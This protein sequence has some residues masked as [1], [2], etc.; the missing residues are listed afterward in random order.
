MAIAVRIARA[1]TGREKVAVCGY[2]GW[3]DWYLA[4]NL[5]TEDALGEH[6]LPGL[7]PTGVPRALVGTTLPF[8]YNHSEELAA[9]IAEHGPDLAA[10][11]M[12]PIRSEQPRTGFLDEVT[13]LARACG[14]VLIVDEVSAGF[15]MNSGGAHLVLGLSPDVAVFSKA[16]G[17]GY[18]IAAV[19]GRGPV[20]QAAQD[21][22]I[23]S[24][25][26]TERIGPVAALATVRKHRELD[27]GRHLMIIGRKVQSGWR[28][29]ARQHGLPIVIS[30]IPPLS[31]FSF[32][33]PNAMALKALYV[34]LMLDHGFLASTSFYAMLAHTEDHVDRYLEAVDEVFG[35]LA[36][37]DESPRSASAV[38]GMPATGRPVASRVW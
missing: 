26:W 16:L 33:A 29:L 32:D 25:Y 28:R 4:A 11:V 15:R 7:Q 20:M 34:Q 21:S 37:L 9:I 6:L 30:G 8:R 13:R 14:S 10:V 3:H 23:S 27:V 31:H 2:H 19:I 17:N 1:C 35:E 38:A 5:G 36:L 12:E 18:P 22:F 24:T